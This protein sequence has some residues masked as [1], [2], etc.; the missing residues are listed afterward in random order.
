M[1]STYSHVTRTSGWMGA[2]WHTPYYGSLGNLSWSCHDRLAHLVA[3]GENDANFAS[4]LENIQARGIGRPF[5]QLFSS[6][7]ASKA[8]FRHSSKFKVS[9]GDLNAK[10]PS[11]A[12]CVCMWY[13]R[14]LFWVLGPLVVHWNLKKGNLLIFAVKK[15]RISRF[16]AF[17]VI[18]INI[19]FHSYSITLITKNC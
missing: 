4:S 15:F 12:F 3:C 14:Y 18:N 11:R 13:S 5:R 17:E 7:L 8:A 1:H 16:L 9:D 2:L 19:F 10:K 6:F